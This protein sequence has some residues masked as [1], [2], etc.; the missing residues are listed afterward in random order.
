MMITHVM[1]VKH[2]IT[3][4][5]NNTLNYVKYPM[6]DVEFDQKFYSFI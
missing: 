3:M 2:I 5:K 6:N 4:A 1:Y